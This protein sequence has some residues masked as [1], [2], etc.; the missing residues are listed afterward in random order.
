MYSLTLYAFCLLLGW[1]F[2]KLFG[3][4][5]VKS[6]LDNIPGPKRTSLFKGN[7]QEIFNRH[8][9]DY[10]QKLGEQYG[11]VVRYHAPLGAR[12]LYVF[13]PKALSHI[14]V[15]DQIYEEPRWFLRFNL[16][17]FGPGL[18]STLG[19][20]HRKQRKLLNPAFS[21]DHMRHMTPIFYN[22]THTLRDTVAAK[23]QDTPTEVNVLHW[24]SRGALEI[25]GQGG[26]G[27]S[28]D[29]F[30][31]DKR[32]AYAEALQELP[33][34]IF[35]L[36]FWRVLLPYV[37]LIV[38]ASIRRAAAPYLPHAAMQRLRQI[39]ETM[40]EQSRR[41]Y[42]TKKILLEKG[43]DAVTHQMSEGRDILSILM[44]ANR[45][46]NE[47]DRLPEDELIAQMTT[48]VLAATDTTSNALGRI[49]HMLS[50]HEEIQGKLRAELFE[51]GSDGEDIPYDQLVDLPYLDA[52]CRETLRLHPPASFINRETR[53]DSILPLSDPIEGED[54]SLITEIA[55]PKDTPL[56]I[57]IRSS[58]RNKA[59]WGDD[60]LEFKPE[61]WLAPLPDALSN[62]HVPGIYANQMTFLG[63][64]RACIGF[65]F[66]QLEMKVVLAVMLRSFKFLPGGK[67]VHW[68][69]A[70]VSY[71]TAGKDSAKPEL[72]LKLEPVKV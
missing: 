22:I 55:V 63:G 52:V 24:L 53:R 50:E 15:K 65:K 16:I 14:V 64:G 6:P 18:V 61:R 68:N 42:E 19:D 30:S 3:L 29:A 41:I 39:I 23:V 71:P 46:A 28:F 62:A 51:A 17:L 47:E 2:W 7:T 69:L 8:G 12:G 43:D 4:Y 25:V 11:Q 34:T 40:D 57:A 37:S 38:P 13:D 58:N 49:F 27:F 5:F 45:E 32:N 70:P 35:A 67:E 72:Y 31:V 1:A 44:K 56:M 20:H 60:A 66:S 9:L 36:H 10:L 21:T 59:L 54:G 48:I 26:L 33:R